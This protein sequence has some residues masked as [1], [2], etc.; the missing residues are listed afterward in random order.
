VGPCDTYFCTSHGQPEIVVR[1]GK[2]KTMEVHH[3]VASGTTVPEFLRAKKIAQD[4]GLIF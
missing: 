4:R 3:P 2:G 1:Y